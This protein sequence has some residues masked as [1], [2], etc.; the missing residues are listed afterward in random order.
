MIERQSVKLG[1]LQPQL[2]ARTVGRH[3]QLRL[4]N[5]RWRSRGLPR[6]VLGVGLPIATDSDAR[7][8][9]LVQI[10]GELFFVQLPERLAARCRNL[11]EP[12]LAG[13]AANECVRH[14]YST[15]VKS[16]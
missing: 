15:F 12:D 4:G 14:D 2:T 1:Q 3:R 8:L 5:A 16:T 13:T 10:R 6:G 9:L 7:M 11:I